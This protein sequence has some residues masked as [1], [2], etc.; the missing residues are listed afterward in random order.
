MRQKISPGH[1]YPARGAGV[2][3]EMTP[4]M[5]VEDVWI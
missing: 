1:D 4:G 5:A 3:A 2:D